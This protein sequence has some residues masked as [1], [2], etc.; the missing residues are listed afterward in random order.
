MLVPPVASSLCQELKEDLCISFS[1]VDSLEMIVL[2]AYEK[3]D[4]LF[5]LTCRMCTS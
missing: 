3:L 5:S 1:L 2:A 4:L